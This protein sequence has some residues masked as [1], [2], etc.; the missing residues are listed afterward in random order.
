MRQEFQ[1]KLFFEDIVDAE[2][3]ER[4]RF[5]FDEF[6]EFNKKL[7]GSNDTIFDNNDYLMLRMKQFM[8]LTD[9]VHSLHLSGK[10]HRDLKEANVM[11]N[12]NGDCE[13]I[14]FGTVL[15]Q[16]D[17]AKVI[18][19]PSYMPSDLYPYI[20]MNRDHTYT[21]A[22]DV[23]SLGCMLERLYIEDLR[24]ALPASL[25][26]ETEDLISQMKY[27]HNESTDKPETDVPSIETVMDHL[28]RVNQYILLQKP[29]DLFLAEPDEVIHYIAAYQA[30]SQDDILKD[31]VQFQVHFA[32][33]NRLTS[34]ADAVLFCEIQFR[35]LFTD[36]IADGPEGQA[37]MAAL[38]DP[39]VNSQLMNQY[40]NSQDL[41]S[42]EQI[43][44]H[45]QQ[46]Q[47]IHKIEGKD[48]INSLGLMIS[49]REWEKA[50][51]AKQK[52]M[53]QKLEKPRKGLLNYFAIKKE[54]RRQKQQQKSQL[55]PPNP[56]KGGGP[57]SS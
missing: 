29:L 2:V 52:E 47:R 13:L 21:G 8:S 50:Q 28:N 20:Y 54:K 46:Y 56:K 36:I 44:Y 26:Q 9:K 35:R 23:F 51:A 42:L 40:L 14:D 43:K 48:L 18:G 19:S 41:R 24:D 53:T 10:V 1:A 15:N 27:T 3:E 55:T 11:F 22:E 33:P 31:Q 37:L 6:K 49:E 34:G 5:T 4:E 12:E 57:A 16:G 45:A 7:L 30:L 25:Q 17:T 32:N 38:H 39:N